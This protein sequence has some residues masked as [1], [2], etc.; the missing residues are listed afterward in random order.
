[1]T[2][3]DKL[4]FKSIKKKILDYT[5]RRP[6][7]EPIKNLPAAKDYIC[8]EG[9]P[10]LWIGYPK[11]KPRKPSKLIAALQ[12]LKSG[13]T[14][15]ELAEDDELGGSVILHRDKLQTFL[16]P[17][18]STNRRGKME[19]FIFYGPS[20]AGKT[21][22]ALKFA[23]ERDPDYCLTSIL[24]GSFFFERM[25]PAAKVLVLDD[26]R[27]A[28]MPF[29]VLL[30]LLE[31]TPLNVSVKGRSVPV[32]ATTIILTSIFHPADQY[33][34]LHSKKKINEPIVQLTR[35][36]TQSFHLDATDE[37]LP[38]PADYQDEGIRRFFLSA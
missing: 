25:D 17:Q 19:V 29:N 24:P 14:F 4:S 3:S 21:S 11:P 33:E 10:A 23:E 18:R 36:I 32:N 28:S 9:P 20:G 6:N 12:A 37:H 35:R 34:E 1:M 22:T 7:I 26:F 5:G 15:D 16:E 2:F 13:R 27:A 30:R 31:G 38:L 8:K